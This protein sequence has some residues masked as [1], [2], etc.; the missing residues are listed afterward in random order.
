MPGAA[1]TKRNL[2]FLLRAVSF[3]KTP[4]ASDS[5]LC[6]L[7]EALLL[8]D[9]IALASGLHFVA[10]STTKLIYDVLLPRAEL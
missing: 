1:F 7:L 5:L 9:W 2:V 10:G 3:F 8:F 6:A 4:Y